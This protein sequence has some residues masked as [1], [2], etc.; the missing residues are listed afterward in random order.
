MSETFNWKG[1]DIVDSHGF[2]NGK[3]L[4]VFDADQ[5][6]VEARYG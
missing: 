6:S 3:R 4:A 2:F 5:I 1:D